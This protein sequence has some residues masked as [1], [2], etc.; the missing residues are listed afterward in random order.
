MAAGVAKKALKIDETFYPEDVFLLWL[1]EN[2]AYT[3]DTAI[4]VPDEYVVAMYTLWS[5]GFVEHTYNDRVFLTGRGR[6]VLKIL[7]MKLS[8]DKRWK[9]YI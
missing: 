3:P 7:K 8:G 5:E 9:Q 2:K 4:I 1:E 6:Q